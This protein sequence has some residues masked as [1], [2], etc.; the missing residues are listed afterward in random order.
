M[1]EQLLSPGIGTCLRGKSSEAGSVP[2][3]HPERRDPRCRFSGEPA[4]TQA[5][6]AQATASRHLSRRACDEEERLQRPHGT[7]SHRALS[8]EY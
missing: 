8:E 4:T 1:L 3:P 5:G 7:G 6:A 2:N